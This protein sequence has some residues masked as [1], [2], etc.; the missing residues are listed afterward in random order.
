MLHCATLWTAKL[1]FMSAMDCM[2]KLVCKDY[3]FECNFV[4]DDD[5]LTNIIEQ[6]HLEKWQ[7]GKR[8]FP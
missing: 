2:A 1:N 8:K 4:A 3:G 5:D 6:I 7:L